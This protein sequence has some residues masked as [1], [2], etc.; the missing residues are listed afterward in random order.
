MLIENAAPS[1]LVPAREI[2]ADD[3]PHNALFLCM[4]L[5]ITCREL[6]ATNDVATFEIT[7]ADTGI[8]MS[9]EFQQHAFEPFVQEAKAGTSTYTGS[10]LG[11]AIVKELVERMGGTI[12]LE[13]EEGVGSTFTVVV[14]F[15]IDHNATETCTHKE[16]TV[17]LHG[18]HA[19][20]VEDD[21]LNA[22]IVEFVL[23]N[24]GLTLERAANGAEAVKMFSQAA[25]GTTAPCSRSWL[26]SASSDGVRVERH[27]VRGRFCLRNRRGCCIA[28]RRAIGK[29]GRRPAKRQADGKQQRQSVQGVRGQ[30]VP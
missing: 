27:L 8:G 3:R 5:A 30:Y 28:G 4:F 15:E 21:D 29:R 22:E 12:S 20:L 2:A 23:G 16:H 10:G 25:P 14:P 11:L 18:K 17:D 26:S 7:C 24:E 6:S 1:H 9:P 19:L 13:S